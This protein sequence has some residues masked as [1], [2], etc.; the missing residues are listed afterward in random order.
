MAGYHTRLTQNA[1]DAEDALRQAMN[2]KSKAFKRHEEAVRLPDEKARWQALR[3]L[4]INLTDVAFA[5][6]EQ[7][8]IS[9][10]GQKWFEVDVER[11]IFHAE[12]F[13]QC[14]LIEFSLD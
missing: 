4:G 3:Q 13:Y 9:N 6:A 12:V 10:S 8:C 11:R 14:Y 7:R 1:H 5:E 2:M